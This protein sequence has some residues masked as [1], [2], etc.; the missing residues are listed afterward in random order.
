SRRSEDPPWKGSL[1]ALMA[2]MAYPPLRNPLRPSP[3]G[4][5]LPM[6]E[7]LDSRLVLESVD[8]TAVATRLWGPP[9]GRRG[10]RSSR[11]LWWRCPFH[12]D[13]NPSLMVDTDRQRW[14]CW[15]CGIGGDAAELVK[16]VHGVNFPESLRL[17]AS[18]AP[19]AP[20]RSPSH[21]TRGTPSSKHLP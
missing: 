2:S 1:M 14:R 15:P 20:K 21:V 11:R 5:R 16:R 18:S 9:P 4:G 6:V 12:D 13:R 17:L 19:L 3:P 7:R 10:E 8:L